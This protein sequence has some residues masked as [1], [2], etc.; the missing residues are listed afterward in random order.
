[1]RAA[2]ILFAAFVVCPRPAHAGPPTNNA[3]PAAA[4]P[5]STGTN[6]LWFPVGETLTYSVYWGFIPVGDAVVTSE[7]IE[8]DGRRL[9]QVTHRIR[10][11]KV[12]ATLYPVNDTVQ[13]V[14][15]PG[16]FRSVS[17]FLDQK[18]GRHSAREVTKFDYAK[19]VA[20]WESMTKAKKKEFAIDQDTRDLVTFMYFMRRDG[21]KVGEDRNFRV[22][23]DEKVYDLNVKVAAEE[24]VAV[25]GY[26]KVACLRLEP[27]AQFNG[28]FVR[29]GKMTVWVSNDKR[30]LCTRVDAGVPI[31]GSVHVYLTSVGGPGD[32]MWVKKEARP[33]GSGDAP[34]T[35]RMRP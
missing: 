27:T 32:D 7:W 34:E 4:A 23:A 22:M 6:L 25:E 29:K 15:D 35:G 11:N 13:T 21:F 19:G 1:M 20:Q 33:K 30:F 14:I 10:S 17:F 9:I 16:T 26:G 5:V 18:E 2:A 12:L 28:L 3:A 24:K 8:D 31:V